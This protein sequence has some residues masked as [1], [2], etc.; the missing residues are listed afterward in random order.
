MW[1]PKYANTQIR[2]IFYNYESS[3]PKINVYDLFSLKFEKS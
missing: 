3:T 2:C 1:Q